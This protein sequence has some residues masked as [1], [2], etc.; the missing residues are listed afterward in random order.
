MVSK[1]ILEALE[2]QTKK[3]QKVVPTYYN[4]AS[5]LGHPCI[6]YLVLK[7]L[8]YEE[9]KPPELDLLRIYLE[10]TK[11]AEL[12][13][14]DLSAAGFP[15]FESERSFKWDEYQIVGHI[16]GVIRYDG[17]EYPVEIK[18]MS[19]FTFPSVNSVQ[20]MLN[21]SSW[22]IQGYP[23]QLNTYL[24][25]S[26]K[27][28]GLFILKEKSSGEIKII[29][30]ELDYGMGEET[31]KKAE[32]IN[33]FVKDN[34]IPDAQYCEACEGCGFYDYCENNFVKITN[35]QQPK[36]IDDPELIE[37]L[38]EYEKL[39]KKKKEFDKIDKL[40]KNKLHG[41]DNVQIGDF[42]ISGKWQERK[43]FVVKA[44]KFWKM[45][46]RRVK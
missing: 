10:G 4:R 8:R 2:S 18:T 13:K 1:K 9:E 30:M 26:D 36:M 17:K 32:R 41:C 42:F 5:N 31:L 3:E 40:I 6:R 28:E 43:E 34:Q 45:S 37:L 15:V 16:D 12:I 7:R 33:Q 27:P 19:P 38:T 29:M 21:H 39:K 14:R 46:I 44:T 23:V 20:D 35:G 11:Q 22:Y 25:L 24:L